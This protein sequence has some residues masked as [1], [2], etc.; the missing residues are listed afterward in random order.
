MSKIHTSLLFKGILDTISDLPK[1]ANL[2][3][4]W[5]VSTT[6]NMYVYSGIDWVCVSTGDAK[7]LSC[8]D[9]ATQTNIP[10]HSPVA[11]ICTQCHGTL[12]LDKF[13]RLHCPYC[14]TLYK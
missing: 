9:S 12:E 10:Q 13:G 5:C 2:G 11:Q 6:D 8:S 3:D 7:L 4:V 1:T 14:G